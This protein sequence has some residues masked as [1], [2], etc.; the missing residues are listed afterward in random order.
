MHNI[1]LLTNSTLW[2]N[3]IIP[4]QCEPTHTHEH[5][6]THA[7]KLSEKVRLLKR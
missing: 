4:L 2:I 3:D 1:E 7:H 6:R 5:T